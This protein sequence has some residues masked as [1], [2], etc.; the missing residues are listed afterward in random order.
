M[1]RLILSDKG[2]GVLARKDRT[3][4]GDIRERWS[5][6]PMDRHAPVEWRNVSGRSSLQLLRNLEHTESV[7]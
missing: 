7:H 3:S 5:A 4:V 1:R 6:N 2:L